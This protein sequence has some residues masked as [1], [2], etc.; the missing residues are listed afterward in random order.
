MPICNCLIISLFLKH[1]LSI[2]DINFHF[3][4]FCVS[5][6]K[7]HKMQRILFS[8][9]ATVNDFQTNGRVNEMG[10][11]LNIHAHH[12]DYK[13][14]LILYTKEY[15]HKA[16][17]LLNYLKKHFGHQRTNI[18]L[19]DVKNVYD[20]LPSIKSK[21][22]ALL[23]SYQKEKIDLLLSTGTGIMKIAW[24]IAHSSLNLNTRLIQV[25]APDDSED[26]FVPDM[27]EIE[28]EQSQTPVTALIRQNNLMRKQKDNFLIS[29]SLQIS[30][31]KAFKIS[32]ADNVS[33]LILGNTG[34][35]KE[36]L[37][38]YIHTNSARKH[39]SFVSI[40]C[41]AFSDQLLESR[42]FGHKKGSFTGAFSDFKG[43]FEHAN[44][45][46]VF[47]DE[48]GD[49]SSYMQQSL[50]RFL[51]EKEIQPIGGRS[52][53]VDV[54]I[55][56][57]TN[58]DIS[59]LIAENKFRSDLF[60]RLGIILHLPDFKNYT[61]EEK[62]SWIEHFIE[63]KKIEFGRKKKLEISKELLNFL[64]QY[65]FPG[66]IREL[67]N[68][69]DNLY[70]FGDEKAKLS[71]L[72]Y[73]LNNKHNDNSLK[74]D[75]IEKKHIHK[76]LKLNGFNKSNSAKILGIALNTLKAKIVKYKL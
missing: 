71:E 3:L 24:Y 49:I 36:V 37:A 18:M 21:I 57:A 9:L 44:G 61:I 66:N 64:L 52:K 23:M 72:P 48:I 59:K 50:L 70:V 12:W 33:V 68:I 65:S 45:G 60:Y 4:T 13:Q 53:K 67:I 10:P 76:V 46:T 51:Q 27:F 39:K 2:F 5:L 28:V 43:V 73:Y 8:W 30:Y 29:K 74:L 63:N 40:N 35:G 15:E 16:L 19:I 34:T 56:A 38:N 58:Q 41:S 26:F 20:D 54:R 7:K 25:L 11:T 32:Q 1:Q 69:V 22:E 14:H 42:L 47:L 62:H 75:D 55:I 17:Q 31:K 6:K